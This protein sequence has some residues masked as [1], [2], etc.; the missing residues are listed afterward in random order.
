MN[1]WEHRLILRDIWRNGDMTFQQRRD[2][3]VRRIRRAPW[4]DDDWRLGEIVDELD[5]SEDAETFDG[6]W[7]SFYD[8]ADSNRVWIAL[9]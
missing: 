9:T 2:E 8:W 4:G 5:D 3:I 1:R 7:E 6:W